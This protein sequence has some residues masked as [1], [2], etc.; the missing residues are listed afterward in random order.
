MP[1]EAV[2]AHNVA[3]KAADKEAGKVFLDVAGKT[4]DLEAASI[5]YLDA[6]NEAYA[7]EIERAQSRGPGVQRQPPWSRRRYR[8][9]PFEDTS[10]GRTL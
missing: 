10:Y 8:S 9:K 2:S 4:V 5:A 6:F 1:K 7:N 3:K